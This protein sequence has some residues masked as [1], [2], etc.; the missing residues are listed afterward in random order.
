MNKLK[1]KRYDIYFALDR[2]EPKPGQ[3]II[4]INKTDWNDFGYHI[5]CD[6]TAKLVDSD[7]SISD[8]LLIGFLSPEGSSELDIKEFEEGYIG[9]KV[10]LNNLN[11]GKGEKISSEKIPNFFSLL[12]SIQSYRNF[13]KQIGVNSA[14]N[15]LF[16]LNDL[17][18]HKEKND[19][20]EWLESAIKSKVFVLAF[21]RNSEPFF[22]F[23]N[24]GS[25]LAGEGQEN[26][27]AISTALDLSFKL[28]GF[29][30]SHE[31]ML[32]FDSADDNLIPKRINVFIGKNGLGKSQAL[33]QFCRA[34]LRYPDAK[35]NLVDSMQSSKR[36]MI[37]RLLAI[38]T[39][40]ETTNTFPAERISTQKMYYRRLNL[41]RKGQ[42]R[43]SKRL[44]ET[45][46]QLA[47]SEEMIGDKDR[48]SLFWEVLKKVMTIGELSIGLKKGNRYGR[49]SIDLQA[50]HD[51]RSE[52]LM[53]EL[54]SN[55]DPNA[56]PKVKINEK[57]FPLSSGQLTFFKFALLCCL[58]IENGSFV[59]MDE[60]E[61]HLHP[62][63]IADFVELLDYIL[64]HTG[65]QAIIATHSAYFVKEVTRAQVYVFKDDN[66]GGIFIDSPRLRTFGSDVDSISQ[67]VFGE[68]PESRLTDKVYNRVKN[69]DF[70]SVD[71]ELSGEISLAALMDIRRRMEQ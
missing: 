28:D 18:V 24:G 30:N 67:F 7:I 59:L 38:G 48:W 39:P 65:S 44:G 5:R 20:V 23:H 16:E 3:I 25:V 51:S 45:L 8:S 46:I 9:L 15:L 6:L 64:E 69:R 43:A 58:H 54:W 17:V 1:D 61:T 41:T 57:Y 70:E 60:P 21:M 62:N 40:G 29:R 63:L 34:A 12:P 27:K 36:P 52:K 19:S 71:K 68:D 53:L 47:R 50:L 66:E 10:A 4:S 26:F 56:E 33:K 11:I 55:I 22:A 13:V 2:I 35:D 31:L 14:N 32:R 49:E 42:G 37:N